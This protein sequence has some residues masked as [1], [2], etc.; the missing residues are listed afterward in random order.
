[1]RTTRTFERASMTVGLEPPGMLSRALEKHTM[2]PVVSV[3]DREFLNFTIFKQGLNDFMT[4]FVS[5]SPDIALKA[6]QFALPRQPYHSLPSNTNIAWS[7]K[8]Q[9]ELTAFMPHASSGDYFVARRA[10]WTCY[11]SV[12]TSTADREFPINEFDYHERGERRRF[13]RAFRD[14]PNW[15]FLQIGAPLPFEQTSKYNKRKI[16][17]RL[18]R[19]DIL[20][21][22]EAWGA[23][24]RTE[25]FWQTDQPSYTFVSTPLGVL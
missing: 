7:P 3:L 13:V 2:R 9:P 18:C 10:S 24:V 22:L 11:V 21:Y 17:D 4:D 5:H 6:V 19:E 16:R 23:R 12:R 8:F 25:E 20:S 1:M 14:Y 15:E